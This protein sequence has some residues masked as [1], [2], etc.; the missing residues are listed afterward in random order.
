MLFYISLYSHEVQHF[1]LT[2]TDCGTRHPEERS[3][4]IVGGED[5]VRGAWPWYAQLKF[6]GSH[7]CGGTLVD[8]KFIVTAAHCVQGSAG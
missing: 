8:N 2:D 6:N 5:A 7:S 4:R 3:N 1:Y